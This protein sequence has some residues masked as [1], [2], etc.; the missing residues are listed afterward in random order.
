MMILEIGMVALHGCIGPLSR[1]R[2]RRSDGDGDEGH[3]PT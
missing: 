3:W 1:G 2:H